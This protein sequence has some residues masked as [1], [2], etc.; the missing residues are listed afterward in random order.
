MRTLH[1]KKTLHLT[2]NTMHNSQGSKALAREERIQQAIHAVLTAGLK[3]NGQPRLSLR[4]TAALFD[5]PQ[6]IFIA[7]Y[8]GRKCRIEAHEHQQLLSPS[9]E[10]VL[11][12]WIKSLGLR[13]VS[14]TQSAVAQYASVILAAP[15][16]DYWV[17]HFRR[18]HPDLTVR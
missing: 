12:E 1:V 17:H 11:K 10:S 3:G 4:A 18:R 13:G 8:A 5:I 16:T 7:C 6:A 15:V 2:F 14:L 9:Q